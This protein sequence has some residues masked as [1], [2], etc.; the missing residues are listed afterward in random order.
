[1]RE[2]NNNILFDRVSVE[3]TR[4]EKTRFRHKTNKAKVRIVAVALARVLIGVDLTIMYRVSDPVHTN[5]YLRV[6]E[7]L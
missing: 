7:L 6:V 3:K 1:V 4:W 2:E 5:I